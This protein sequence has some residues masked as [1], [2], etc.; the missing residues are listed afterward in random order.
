MR[1]ASSTYG[2]GAFM[3]QEAKKND[4]LGGKTDRDYHK[5]SIA[6]FSI[7]NMSR[8]YFSLRRLLYES[9]LENYGI[10][11]SPVT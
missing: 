9:K 7:K 11:F 1:I 5:N 6:E 10:F 4:F 8:K 2:F 3:N